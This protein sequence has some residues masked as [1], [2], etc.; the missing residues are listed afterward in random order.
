MEVRSQADTSFGIP[1]RNCRYACIILLIARIR[2]QH[3]KHLGRIGY[4]V[5]VLATTAV[6]RPPPTTKPSFQGISPS[7]SS[8]SITHRIAL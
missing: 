7:S 4:D 5:P 2:V 8:K 6:I 1:A 3:H